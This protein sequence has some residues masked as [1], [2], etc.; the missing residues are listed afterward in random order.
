[1]GDIRVI[2]VNCRGLGDKL[3]RNDVFAYWKEQQPSILC[4][5]DIRISPDIEE[6]VKNEW[7]YE[8]IVCPLRSNARGV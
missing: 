4:L 2:S 5:Q 3:K 6:C 1:M 8:C 7:G